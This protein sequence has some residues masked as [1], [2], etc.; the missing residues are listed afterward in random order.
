DITTDVR[1]DFKDGK[2]R[3]RRANPNDRSVLNVPQLVAAIAGL[4]ES[5]RE[6]TEG[7]VS[8]PL[9]PKGYVI[10]AISCDVRS[11][12]AKTV[13]LEQRSLLPL[14]VDDAI[15][16]RERMRGLVVAAK[17]N[18]TVRSFI[19]RIEQH[20]NTSQL[21]VLASEVHKVYPLGAE[22]IHRPEET[23]DI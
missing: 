14:H 22:T 13:V 16:L 2:P 23:D 1:F 9:Q 17:I 5:R 10:G 3:L 4:P 19:A 6:D 21:A 15:D 12:D 11:E 20:Q 8:F 18:P 7:S